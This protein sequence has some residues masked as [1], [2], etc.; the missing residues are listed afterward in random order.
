MNKRQAEGT[1]VLGAT[2]AVLGTVGGNLLGNAIEPLKQV[3]TPDM[4]WGVH[5][6]DGTVSHFMNTTTLNQP[7]HDAVVNSS[8]AAGAAI[9]GAA[10][11]AAGL[12]LSRKNRNLGRQFK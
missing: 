11:V 9:M 5:N 8:T 4:S 7:I 10:G 6:F 12:Y 1:A 2:G 3:K